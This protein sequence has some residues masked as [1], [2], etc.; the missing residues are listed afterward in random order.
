MCLYLWGAVK[1]SLSCRK[2]RCSLSSPWESVTCA[3]VD[4]RNTL[5]KSILWCIRMCHRTVS[6][7]VA[8]QTSMKTHSSGSGSYRNRSKVVSICRLLWNWTGF[9]A[10]VC[11]ERFVL[12]DTESN[13]VVNTTGINYY[14][15]SVVWCQAEVF[16]STPAL[17]TNMEIHVKF[18]GTG[19]GGG[20]SLSKHPVWGGTGSPY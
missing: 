2:I 6:L 19:A 18:T 17:Y 8:T 12:L 11:Q 20:K 3:I 14:K 7:C 15:Q 13:R 16:I 1:C 5:Y 4:D 9:P 10:H